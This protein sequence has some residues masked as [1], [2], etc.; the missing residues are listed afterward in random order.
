MIIITD[1]TIMPDGR[2]FF[3]WKNELTMLRAGEP[4][5][6]KANKRLTDL[7]KLFRI[8]E[9]RW[10]EIPAT[11]D[12]NILIRRSDVIMNKDFQYHPEK[13]CEITKA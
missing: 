9:F 5:I 3:A 7:F 10:N 6:A 13:Y 2:P 12:F 1:E 8:I 11:G 4:R